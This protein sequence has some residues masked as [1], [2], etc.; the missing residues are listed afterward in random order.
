[1]TWALYPF[2]TE[3]L[4]ERLFIFKNAIPPG[5]G[6]AYMGKEAFHEEVCVFYTLL[7]YTFSIV[8]LRNIEKEKGLS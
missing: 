6:L 5:E 7:S 2:G 8:P 1:M 4:L 3:K